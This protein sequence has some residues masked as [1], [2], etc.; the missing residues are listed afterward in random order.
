MCNI[1]LMRFYLYRIIFN[2]IFNDYDHFYL[3]NLTVIE[4]DNQNKM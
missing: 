4:K 3:K 2:I 1:L